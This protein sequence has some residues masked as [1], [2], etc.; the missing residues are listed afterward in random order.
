MSDYTTADAVYTTRRR[1]TT[2]A[3]CYEIPSSAIAMHFG[4]K[5]APPERR[6]HLHVRL[7]AGGYVACPGCGRLLTATEFLETD[8]ER[9]EG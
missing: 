9:K 1:D 4:R 5:D 3:S 7:V 6:P 2:R 8:C